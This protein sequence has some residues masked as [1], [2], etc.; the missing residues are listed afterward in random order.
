M[1][2]AIAILGPTAS[3]KSAVAEAVASELDCK[4]LN[5]DAFQMYRGLDVG[6]NKP[7]NRARYEMLDVLDPAEANTV[8]KFLRR[9]RGICEQLFAESRDVVVCGGTGLYVRALFEDYEVSRAP[10]AALR[11]EIAKMISAV[12][13]E[14]ALARFGIALNVVSAQTL[15]N[16]RHLARFIERSQMDREKPPE[17]QWHT[18]RHKFA[19]EIPKTELDGRIE[20]RTQA[21]IAQGW[22][23]EVSGLLGSGYSEDSPAFKAIGYGELAQVVRGNL[24][25]EEARERIIV[26]TR[27]YAKRQIT[28][29]RREPNCRRLEWCEDPAVM[30]K[31]VLDAIA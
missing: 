31:Q 6:T 20:A 13:G 7:A 27:Q 16:P 14:Q 29:L 1:P 11:D 26:R 10:D 30:A 15:S 2:K 25:L 19:I 4:I 8:G 21:M 3:G 17:Q 28:W 24:T 5:A 18:E 12:G 23:E 22:V 9:A